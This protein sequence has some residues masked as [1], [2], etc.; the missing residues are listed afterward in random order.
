MLSEKL[1][2]N[3]VTFARLDL[4]LEKLDDEGGQVDVN[5]LSTYPGRYLHYVIHTM[6]T[7]IQNDN[8]QL[9][10][11]WSYRLLGAIEIFYE[12]DD[13]LGCSRISDGTMDEVLNIVNSIDHTLEHDQKTEVE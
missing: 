1:A 11:K 5:F 10:I 2:E 4:L 6:R 13:T 9:L 8:A 7:Y 12:D 3:G